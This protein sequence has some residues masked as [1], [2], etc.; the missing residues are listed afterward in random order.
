MEVVLL[1]TGSARGWPEPGCPCASCSTAVTLR[2]ARAPSAVL[3]DDVLL[4]DGSEGVQRAAACAGRTLSGVRSVLLSDVE[5]HLTAPLTGLL[6]SGPAVDL[7]GPPAALAPYRSLLA[8]EHRV[9]LVPISPGHRLP[10]GDH[11]LRARARGDGLAW[12]ITAPDGARLLYAPGVAPLQEHPGAEKAY[13]LVVL[14]I[15]SGAGASTLARLRASGGVT[16]STRVVTTGHGHDDGLPDALGPRLRAWGAHAPPD[17]TA[18]VVQRGT[19]SRAPDDDRLRGRTLVLGGARSGK[20]VLAE[21]LL[22]ASPGVTYV[23]TGGTR[24]DDPEWQDRVAAHVARRPASWSTVETTDVAGCLRVAQGP[25]LIDCLGTWLTARL[26]HHRVWGGAPT[27]AVDADVEQLVAA[28]RTATV[29][30]VAVSNEVGGGIVP[31]TASGRLFRDLLG[32]L[33]AKVAAESETVLF[34]VAGIALP[35]RRA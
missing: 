35:L 3:V 4:L 21:R 16:G 19:Q 2:T 32:R 17:G 10:A 9:R 22:A 6:R 12:D 11:L 26:D 5:Q 15:G 8:A 29:P 7:L 24:A 25:L 14:G 33:N 31:A 28:W 20:S 30:V 23:A 13:D 1:G 18:L 34:T 27:T